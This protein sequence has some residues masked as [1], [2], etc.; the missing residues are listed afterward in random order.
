MEPRVLRVYTPANL[1]GKCTKCNLILADEPEVSVI[2]LGG[3]CPVCREPITPE[4]F[5]YHVDLHKIRRKIRWITPQGL[6]C[7]EQPTKDYSIEGT[8]Y[9]ATPPTGRLSSIPQARKGLKKVKIPYL[10]LV[11][12]P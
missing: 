7:N 6:W 9:F 8:S 2:D 11:R 10:R 4:T 5:G 12:S 1:I 3:L